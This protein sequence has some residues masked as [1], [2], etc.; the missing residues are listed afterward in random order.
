MVVFLSIIWCYFQEFTL[1]GFREI[2]LFLGGCLFMPHP[3]HFRG[4]LPPDVILPPQNA[5][6]V[7]LLCSP[8]LATLLH[9]ASAAGVSQT[10]RRD[11]KEW[12]YGTFAE[13]A[14]YIWLGNHHIGHW[15]TF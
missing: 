14:T 15:P 8:I 4:L 13:G 7:Q 12:N 5:L 1:H 9:S 10:L 2:E 11:N 6:Y 3:V